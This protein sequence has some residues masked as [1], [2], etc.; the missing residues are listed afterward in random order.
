[1]QDEEAMRELERRQDE[2]ERAL[3]TALWEEAMEKAIEDGLN[4][5]TGEPEG[6]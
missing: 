2:E 3:E 5:W 6:E 1:M 4:P